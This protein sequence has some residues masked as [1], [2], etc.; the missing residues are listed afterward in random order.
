M[1]YFVVVNNNPVTT[2]LRSDF[3]S[4]VEQAN[5][6]AEHMRANA[7]VMSVTESEVAVAHITFYNGS[8]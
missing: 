2:L 6:W 8:K 5:I 4:A 3:S 7:T 1:K